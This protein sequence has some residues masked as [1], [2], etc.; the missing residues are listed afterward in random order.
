MFN[1]IRLLQICTYMRNQLLKDS[2]WASMANSVEIRV[3]FVDE[4][5]IDFVLRLNHSQIGASKAIM[6]KM[7]KPEIVELTKNRKKTGFSTPFHNWFMEKQGIF[8]PS[9]KM[10]AKYIAQYKL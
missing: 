6:F 4:K 2:D 9:L 1:Q 7:Q 5:V 3:P 8:D 10:W